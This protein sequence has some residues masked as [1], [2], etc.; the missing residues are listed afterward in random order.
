MRLAFIGRQARAGEINSGERMLAGGG[1]L[2]GRPNSGEAAVVG[3]DDLLGGFP[4]AG[5][6]LPGG[7]DF[8]ECFPPAK[9]PFAKCYR[10][11]KQ[12]ILRAKNVTAGV[13]HDYPS[14]VFNY[15]GR[16][17]V[18]I[19]RWRFGPYHKRKQGSG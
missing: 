5:G 15:E 13:T 12:L 1:C 6:P 17:R 19:C 2:V 4:P 3:G 8:F 7:D 10:K 9:R 14:S 16:N 11:T 18:R